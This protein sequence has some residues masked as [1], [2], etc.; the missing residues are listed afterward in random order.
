MNQTPA[1]QNGPV[2]DVIQLI[3]TGDTLR[4]A[5]KQVG[6]TPSAFAYRLQSDREAAI[7]YGRAQEL[8]ADFLVDEALHIADHE[9]DAAKARNQIDIRKWTASRL[10]QKKW[11]DRIDLNVTQ[12]LDIGQTLAEARARLCPVRDQ[13]EII[14]AQVI[15]IPDDSR[16]KPSDNESLTPAQN[17]A[18]PDIFS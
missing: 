11:G 10:H 8:R 1:V 6:L 7:A 15:E 4:S 14:E 2:Y 3:L 12:T 18:L 16:P 9:E 13:H 17:P 5:L